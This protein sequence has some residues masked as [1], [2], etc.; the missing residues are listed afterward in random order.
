M[1]RRK[2]YDSYYYPR[3]T[4]SKPRPVE[5]GIQLKSSRGSI[6]EH[7][8]SK[9]W[10]DALER[11]TI[12]SR[13]SRGKTYARAGQVASID[14]TG[15][16]LNAKVQGSSSRPYSVTI[17]L[18]SLTAGEWKEV[19]AVMGDQAIF[20]AKLLCGEMPDNIEDAFKE[21]KIPLFPSGKRD[22]RTKCSCPDTANPCKH[23]AAVHYILAERFDEDPFLLFELRGRSKES[24]I[25]TMRE[26]RSKDVVS[27][28]G[29]G[30][31][32]S[33][34]SLPATTTRDGRVNPDPVSFW[35]TKDEVPELPVTLRPPAMPHPMLKSLGASN[36]S[37]DGKPLEDILM[38]A[39]D[40]VTRTATARFV[41]GSTGTGGSPAREMGTTGNS[42]TT[43]RSAH[44]IEIS[45]QVPALRGHE[46]ILLHAMTVAS[47]NKRKRGTITRSTLTKRLPSSLPETSLDT[48]F[49]ILDSRFHAI[50]MAGNPTFVLKEAGRAFLE[51]SGLI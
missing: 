43:T 49:S 46:E 24:I 19:L 28:D 17:E 1:T 50:A 12:A 9:R 41:D 15:G 38:L 51:C 47:K 39:C 42:K 8:W 3:Y 6:G 14:I 21:A 37:I 44:L 2:N 35:G 16:K 18:V 20:S 36:M 26:R 48:L 5:D 4:P 29:P 31:T 25:E 34:A 33:T 22:L 13:L 23:V 7:W 32:S 10:I 27:D 11:F 30:D 40:I 45:K